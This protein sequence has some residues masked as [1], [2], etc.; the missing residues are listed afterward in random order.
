M[1][2]KP[3]PRRRKPASRTRPPVRRD[4]VGE[5]RVAPW[6]QWLLGA[7]VIGGFGYFLYTLSVAP[8]PLPE[9][10]AEKP[11]AA[12]PKA[13]PG[14]K[15]ESEPKKAS[16]RFTFYTILPEKEVVVPEGEVKARK[17]QERLGRKPAGRYFIQAGS[18]RSHGDADRLKARLALLG[19]EAR[20]QQ[21]RVKGTLWHR[22]KMGPFASMNEV[23]RIRARLRKYHIDSVVQTARQ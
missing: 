10:E 7:L 21:A 22:V 9:A 1:A 8:A 18:F 12:K 5:R 13:A 6:W 23:E 3:A 14:P 19:V 15:T 2:R 20:I 16:P 4:G 11:V 17:R